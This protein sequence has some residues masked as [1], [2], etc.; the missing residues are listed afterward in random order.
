[1]QSSKHA[2]TYPLWRLGGG[3]AW[4]KW[5]LFCLGLS[6]R[7]F[8][9]WNRHQSKSLNV[10]ERN[11]ILSSFSVCELN[12]SGRYMHRDS[13]GMFLWSS[14]CNYSHTEIFILWIVI[15]FQCF[16]YLQLDT[17]FDLWIVLYLSA[18]QYIHTHTVL[19]ILRALWLGTGISLC[20]FANRI[21]IF[22]VSFLCAQSY[23]NIDPLD[24]SMHIQNW[25]IHVCIT[26]WFTWGM[27]WY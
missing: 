13:S 24:I 9:C 1:M 21:H 4:C 19:Y 23:A 17:N 6:L 10:S 14:G 15:I 11:I 5:L 7:E 3:S 12:S 18:V 26:W 20:W 8:P 22:T 27:V 2:F 16:Q 25:K